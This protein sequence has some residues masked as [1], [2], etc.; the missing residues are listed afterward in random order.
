MGKAS[1]MGAIASEA[2]LIET[3]LVPLAAQ[4]PGAL[5]LKDD[6]RLSASAARHTIS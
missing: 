4:M 5:G 3:Y 6:A 2:E 1:V